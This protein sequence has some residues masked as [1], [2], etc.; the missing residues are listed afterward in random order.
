MSGK[1][2]IDEAVDRAKKI[3]PQRMKEVD[4]RKGIIPQGQKKPSPKELVEAVNTLYPKQIFI[5]DGSDEQIFISPLILFVMTFQNDVK[6]SKQFL[7]EYAKG[8][9]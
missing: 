5:R 7:K 6:D 8:V 1:N 9:K 4:E 3:I 2:R